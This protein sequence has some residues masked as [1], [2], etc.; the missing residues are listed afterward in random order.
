MKNGVTLILLACGVQVGLVGLGLFAVSADESG[1]TLEATGWLHGT[2]DPW[3]PW[4][5]LHR[6]L[7]GLAL[8]VHPDLF[9]T[10]RLVTFVLS[11]A[12]VTGV[13]G[14]AA[15]LFEDR[16][17]TVLS[18][19]LAVSFPPR[20]ILG[21]VPLS[22]TLFAACLVPAATLLHRAE[23]Q[24]SNRSLLG[25]CVLVALACGVRY[26]GWIVAV[27]ISVTLAILAAKRHLPMTVAA[28]SIVLLGAVPAGW[29]L[30]SFLAGKP[31][32]FLHST[33]NRFVEIHGDSPATLWTYGL[34]WQFLRQS[35]LTLN[36]LGLVRL[37]GLC[38]TDPWLRRATGLA[39]ATFL[40]TA[41]VTT[42][43]RGMPTDIFWRMPFV[44][45]LLL[46]PFT[47][48]ALSDLPRWNHVATGILILLHLVQVERLARRNT[49]GPDDRAMG[50]WIQ[51]HVEPGCRIELDTRGWSYLHVM[52]ASNHPEQFVRGSAEGAACR[53]RLVEAPALPAAPPV[54]A[55]GKWTLSTSRSPASR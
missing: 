14:L 25:G 1:R 50:L 13:M 9:W 23:R 3:T 54:H 33:V 29:V 2:M 47:A 55:T 15:Q 28:G 37:I 34:P 51:E 40:L 43:T 5:P 22:E 8:W 7:H 32:Y 17:L 52:I 16:R 10:P 24:G 27:V 12:V 20:A 31:F 45:S 48:R 26:E 41:L 53:F 42:I 21:A 30:Q 46:L 35:L 44:W 39:A 19:L 18:G 6:V 11:L 38:R 36:I 49:F 4:L